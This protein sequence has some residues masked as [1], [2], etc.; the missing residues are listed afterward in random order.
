[1]RLLADAGQVTPGSH[2]IA[3]EVRA[4]DDPGVAVRET[5]TFLGLRR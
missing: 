5:T 1:V 2:K 3:V 4:D